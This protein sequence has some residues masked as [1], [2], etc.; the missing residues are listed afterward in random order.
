MAA[1]LSG[2]SLIGLQVIRVG[3][4]DLTIFQEKQTYFLRWHASDKNV[5]FSED[6][7]QAR[8]GRRD[9][10]WGIAYNVA[11]I[12]LGIPRYATN[13]I[14]DAFRRK[15][16]RFVHRRPDQSAN[17]QNA[18]VGGDQINYVTWLAATVGCGNFIRGEVN[19]MQDVPE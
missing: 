10:N 2:V 9:I 16:R 17:R 3:L 14:D 19:G 15:S 12:C 8:H 5:R 1:T 6:F 4:H 18:V 7:A 11:E 13:L